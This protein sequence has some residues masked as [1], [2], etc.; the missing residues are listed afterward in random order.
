MGYVCNSSKLV[1][2]FCDCKFIFHIAQCLWIV[3]FWTLH[4]WIYCIWEALYPRHQFVW[5]GKSFIWM[6]NICLT[7]H[8]KFLFCFVPTLKMYARS[9]L[10]LFRGMSWGAH[11]HLYPWHHTFCCCMSN[12]EIYHIFWPQA[13]NSQMIEYLF[14]YFLISYLTLAQYKRLFDI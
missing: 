9:T 7:Y 10:M 12:K 3:P 2:K 4:R 5:R 14:W 13:S 11:K 8:L 1:H 6:E